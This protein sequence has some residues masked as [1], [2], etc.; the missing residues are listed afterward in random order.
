[1]ASI[2]S[3][4]WAFPVINPAMPHIMLTALWRNRILKRD[5][6]YSFY[7]RGEALTASACSD[8]LRRDAQYEFW[9]KSLFSVEF[10]IAF[11]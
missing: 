10:Y 4:G 5:V 2:T 8:K 7:A 3:V 6:F 1:M 11:N 9:L